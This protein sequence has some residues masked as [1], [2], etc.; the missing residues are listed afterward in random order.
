MARLLFFGKLGDLAGGRERK[1]PLPAGV[2]TLN[3]LIKAIEKD[4]H[5]LG[6]A[7]GEISVRYVINEN[8]VDRFQ[9]INECDEIGFLPPVSGG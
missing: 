4:D 9:T 3:D 2:N 8:I 1:I 6:N 7:I 5:V